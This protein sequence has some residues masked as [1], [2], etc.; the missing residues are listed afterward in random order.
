VRRRNPE[1][2]T[3]VLNESNPFKRPLIDQVSCF[4]I[5]SF[6]NLT[7]FPC[8]N[9]GKN[10]QG[11]SNRITLRCFITAVNVHVTNSYIPIGG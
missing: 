4:R 1:L 7:H 9:E 6:C 8:S 10:I 11:C 5:V 3:E 2:W